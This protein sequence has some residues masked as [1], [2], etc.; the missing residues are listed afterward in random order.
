MFILLPSINSGAVWYPDKLSLA[1]LNEEVLQKL[2]SVVLELWYH[3]DVAS[4]VLSGPLCTYRIHCSIFEG[5]QVEG[6][7]LHLRLLTYL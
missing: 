2:C 6:G 7:M 1:L 5:S 4:S 3:I